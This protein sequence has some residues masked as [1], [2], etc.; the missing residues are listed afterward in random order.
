MPSQ[1][2]FLG[3]NCTV[4]TDLRLN[5]I[6]F[7]LKFTIVQLNLISIMSFSQKKKVK[8]C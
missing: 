6:E 8:S 1:E 3:M 4:K 2:Q 5:L 7:E